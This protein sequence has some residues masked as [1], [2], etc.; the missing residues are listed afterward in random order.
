MRNISFFKVSTHCPVEEFLDSLL[1]KE[2]QKITW[3][4]QLIE[5]LTKV[6]EQYFKK[7]K[8][9]NDIWEIRVQQGYNI[10]RV[11]GFFLDSNHFVATNGFK[12]KTQ[13][14]PKIEINL[15]EKRKLEYLKQL[16][17]KP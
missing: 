4:L 3:V 9:T 7:L 17:G 16:K 2:A 8:N 15:A 12:K 1:P 13:K 6:P 11:L 14:T 10:F 5:E